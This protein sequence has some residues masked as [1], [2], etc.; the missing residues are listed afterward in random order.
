MKALVLGISGQVGSYLAEILLDKDYEVYGLVRR[1]ST[2]NLDRIMHVLDKIR[3]VNGDMTD[4]TSLD[5]AI[6]RIRPD[7]VYNLAAQSYV[8][9][10]WDQP[11]LT[12]DITGLGVMRILEAIRKYAPETTRFVTASSSEMFGNV[13]ETPQT[14]KTPFW[15]RS[16]YGCAKALGHWVTVNARESWGAFACSAIFFNMES[17]R[18]GLEFVTRKIT[19]AVARIKSGL[20]K[21]LRL[22]N[23][24]SIRDW[25]Y[26]PEYAMGMYLMLQQNNPDD[27][28]F[29]TGQA[30]TVK[31]WLETAFGYARLD[32][33]DYVIIDENLKRPAE[34][35]L[36][37][38]NASKAKQIL[39]WEAKMPF[40]EIVKRMVD[41]DMELVGKAS[42][43]CTSATHHNG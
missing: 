10:S 4:Q 29:A 37:L 1:S 43:M 13:Q 9:T 42:T 32:W 12:M 27:F 17:K 19:H 5:E 26:A 33:R 41:A 22:G 15:P 40:E 38:G 20:Q 31:T 35:D 18:R 28:V 36:L 8:H 14:E 3:V 24:D 30:R 11:F 25:G 39:G 21:E 34:V 23:L 2:N 7:E 6:R 16:P